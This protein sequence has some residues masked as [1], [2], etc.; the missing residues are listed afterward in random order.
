M[1]SPM[2]AVELG[3][4]ALLESS[5]WSSEICRSTGSVFSVALLKMLKSFRN[6]TEIKYRQGRVETRGVD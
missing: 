6:S 1:V 3:P 2:G 5:V 4:P